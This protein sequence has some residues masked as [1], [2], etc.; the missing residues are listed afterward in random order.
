[1]AT[2]R[3]PKKGKYPRKPKAN[4]SVSSMNGYLEKVKAIDKKFADSTVA[5][6]KELK[7]RTEL[8]A[9]ISKVTR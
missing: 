7:T 6:S 9:K 3:K 5:Y 4:A 1:M 8:K 2:L